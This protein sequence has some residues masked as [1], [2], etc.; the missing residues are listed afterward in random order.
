MNTITDK[1]I[2]DVVNNQMKYICS[3]H[4]EKQI[5]GVFSHGR[6]NHGFAESINDIQT[7]VY[8][9]PTFEEMCITPTPV[10]DVFISYKNTKIRQVD[11]RLLYELIKKQD[12]VIMESLFS[13]YSIINPR[14]EKVFKKYLYINKEA[15]FHCDQKARI[16]N[17]VNCAKKSLEDFEKTGNYESLFEA[18]RLR[19]G[20]KLY[21]DGVSIENCIN[22]KRDYHINYLWQIKH[23]ELTPD[24]QEIKDDFALF[25]K[26]AQSFKVNTACRDLIKNAVVEI[27][28]IALTDMTQD[29]DFEEKLTDLEKQALEII[30]DN[31][32]DGYEGNIS[33][34][35]LTNSSNIS[36]P[37]FKSVLQKMQDNLIAEVVNKGV[38]GTYIKIM[39]GNLLS[40]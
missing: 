9:L 23:K 36:R 28:K 37:V 30:L 34:S 7:I 21:I 18:C 39:D 13:E 1:Q 11:I 5:L 12:R 6:V 22:L 35:Q 19:I 8:V 40:R 2:I 25:L 14:Y 3:I 16:V 10:E 32:A 20:C 31:L 29:G 4:D 24:L 33:I 38:K 27:L 15:I 17:S 26:E